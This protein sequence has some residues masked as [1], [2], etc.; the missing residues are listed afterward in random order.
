LGIGVLGYI[1]ILYHKEHPPE[2]W[3][4]SS[5]DTLYIYIYIEREREREREQAVYGFP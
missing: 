5:W 3:H 1:G 2:V 4:N